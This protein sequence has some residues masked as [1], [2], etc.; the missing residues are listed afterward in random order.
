MFHLARS[1]AAQYAARPLG[2]GLVAVDA[3]R[4]LHHHRSAGDRVF[5]A[6]LRGD[7]EAAQ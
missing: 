2:V 7:H 3:S 5:R 1:R 6:V 4:L